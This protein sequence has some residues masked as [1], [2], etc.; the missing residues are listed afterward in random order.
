[1]VNDVDTPPLRQ[2][3]HPAFH[4]PLTARTCQG[5]TGEGTHPDTSIAQPQPM[6]N[7]EMSPKLTTAMKVAAHKPA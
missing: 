1:M 4:I 6:P 7:S 2:S 3:P 5:K